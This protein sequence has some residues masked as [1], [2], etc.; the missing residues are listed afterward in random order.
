[1]AEIYQESYLTVAATRAQN[2]QHGFLFDFPDDTVHYGIV[3]E[4][5]WDKDVSEYRTFHA[6]FQIN[7]KSSKSD[8][9]PL[10]R[11]AWCVQ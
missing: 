8:S 11:R 9:T 5:P 1:M 3:A 10:D 2:S 6:T 4:A 7:H